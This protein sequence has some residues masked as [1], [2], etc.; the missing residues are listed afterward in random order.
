MIYAQIAP[1]AA[2]QS[3]SAQASLSAVI[4]KSTKCSPS[5]A[6]AKELN[7]AVTYYLAKDAV[8]LSMVD[9]PGFR[10]MVSKLNPCYQLL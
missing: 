5:S 9:K 8:P 6:Q 2:K 7:R 1:K 4:S 3:S 10:C